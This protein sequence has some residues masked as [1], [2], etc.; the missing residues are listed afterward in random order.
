MNKKEI[1]E[2]LTKKAKLTGELSPSGSYIKELISKRS[3]YEE[4]LN[5]G[6]E[7]IEA[8][9]SGLVSYKVDGLEDV[10][11]YEF[12]VIDNLHIRININKEEVPNIIN[13]LIQNGYLIYEIKLSEV[14]LED[15]FLEKAGGNVID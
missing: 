12:E 11:K 4:Q 9:V 7:Y 14:S 13:L 3:K 5:S 15:A 1:N 10:L 2:S 6:S 8:T